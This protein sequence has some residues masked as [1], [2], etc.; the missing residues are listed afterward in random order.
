MRAVGSEYWTAASL[1]NRG[2]K[3][4]IG[5]MTVDKSTYADVVES[6]LKH[7]VEEG[8]VRLRYWTA[9]G[10]GKWLKKAAKTE[11]DGTRN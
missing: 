3:L 2:T 10:T 1:R 6:K 4:K 8:A 9:A 11:K 5:K 7:E